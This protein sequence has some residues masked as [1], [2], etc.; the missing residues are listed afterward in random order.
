MQKRQVLLM[1]LLAVG[2]TLNTFAQNPLY[3]ARNFQSA[4]ERNTRTAAGA[5][6]PGYW[7]NRATYDIDVTIDPRGRQV[8]GRARI[9]YV[10]QSPDALSRLN[11]KLFQNVHRPETFRAGAVD[12]RFFTDGLFIDA[13]KVDEQTIAWNN[14]AVHR[15]ED[16]TNAWLYLPRAIQPADSV[17]L[18]ISWHYTLQTSVSD[19][20]EG[21]VDSTALFCAYWYPRVAVYDD[22]N[23]WDRI[24]MNNQIEFYNDYNDYNVVIRTP[25]NYL[26]WATGELQ[27]ANE[28]LRAPY[29]DR[30]TASRTSDQTRSIVTEEDLEA[31]AVTLPKD[32][33]LWRFRARNVNDFAFGLSDHF[34]WDATSIRVDSASGRRVHIQTAYSPKSVDFPEVAGIAR[35]C[36]RYFSDR[37][38]GIPY[39]YPTLSLFNGHGQMEYPMM[40]NDN[41]M[42]TL[43]DT[44]ALTAH[45]IA[46][47]YF[48]FLVG[49]N[50]SAFAWMDEGWATLFEYYVCTDFYT[51]RNPEQAIYPG[52]YLRR[53][54][55]DEQP[56]TEVPI[57]TPSHHL[58]GTA[59]G[60]NAYGKS[61]AAYRALEHLL[62]PAEFQRCLH[63]Y[64]D[65][66]RDKHPSPYDFFFTFSD[67]SGR[68][69]SWFWQRWFMRY[70]TMDLALVDYRQEGKTTYVRVHN[71]GGKPLPTILET[72]AR[73]GRRERFT[74]SPALWENSDEA[75]VA[76]AGAGQVVEVRLVWED[77]V[78]VAPQNDRLKINK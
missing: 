57:F 46:H 67:V 7:Q 17:T 36:I 49:T 21:M 56:A 31:G 48:P 52:Y 70:N 34:L 42:P 64:V 63:A 16:P 24:P 11:L 32:Q 47:T 50:E 74:F 29:L 66:W 76:L 78:D 28:V 14:G 38:P 53:Y 1:L 68:D 77:F 20:R 73:D 69:L 27:N 25:R 6:G 37:K 62:G 41:D 10:N 55:R 72:T 33:L 23:G 59:Y 44:R 18:E 54:L 5:P 60:L 2:F 71:A 35:E 19:H 51:L 58:L 3:V 4:M 12:D 75:E 61:A 26:V 65:R 39:P 13:V 9:R 8:G 15:S 40:V 22:L 43:D 45:E 30:L